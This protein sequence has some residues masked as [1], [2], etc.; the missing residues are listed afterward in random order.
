MTS[1]QAAE[2]M[3]KFILSH[4]GEK[5]IF[6]NL[7]AKSKFDY[8]LVSQFNYHLPIVGRREAIQRAIRNAEI[9]KGDDFSIYENKTMTVK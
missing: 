3:K 2:R 5:V 8:V 4:K 7:D 1:K 9:H 6:R